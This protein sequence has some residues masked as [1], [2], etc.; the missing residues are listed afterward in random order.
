[1]KDIAT[2]A[3]DRRVER[4]IHT[5]TACNVI[6]QPGWITFARI[7]QGENAFAREL[8]ARSRAGLIPC[9]P[10]RIEDAVPVPVS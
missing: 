7:R 2:A 8:A 4:F 10:C 9:S 1:M 5:R 6:D 3:F